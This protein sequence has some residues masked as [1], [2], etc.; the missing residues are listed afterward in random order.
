MTSFGRDGTTE[1]ARVTPVT[2]PSGHGIN[3]RAGVCL[4]VCCLFSEVFQ[5][6]RVRDDNFLSGS[7]LAQR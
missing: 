2:P 5:T 6:S 4:M 3:R 1:I 7:G